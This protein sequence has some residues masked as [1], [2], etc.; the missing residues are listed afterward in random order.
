M[1]RWL[2]AGAL[3]LGLFVCG[4]LLFYWFLKVMFP[5]SLVV[6]LCL[7]LGYEIQSRRQGIEI[8]IKYDDDVDR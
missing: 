2:L 5:W 4:I 8:R 7:A 3:C 6:V 1:I